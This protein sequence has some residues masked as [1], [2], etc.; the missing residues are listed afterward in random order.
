MS[1]DG[2]DTAAHPAINSTGRALCAPGPSGVQFV[3]RTEGVATIRIS[4]SNSTQPQPLVVPQL[5]HL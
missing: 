5:A 2:G 3:V 1:S 4:A